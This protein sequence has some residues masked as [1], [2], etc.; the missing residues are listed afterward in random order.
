MMLVALLV[1]GGSGVVVGC[2]A[3]AMSDMF[4][5]QRTRLQGWG[6]GLLVASVALLG[7]AFP[8]I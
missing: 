7:L 5:A 8:L 4:P 2:V 1:L 6:G 3:A